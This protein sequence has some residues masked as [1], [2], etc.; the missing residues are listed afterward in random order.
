MQVFSFSIVSWALKEKITAPAPSFTPTPR[1]GQLHQSIQTDAVRHRVVDFSFIPSTP[2]WKPGCQ[3]YCIVLD[4]IV[5]PHSGIR[6]C[7]RWCCR[8]SGTT[9]GHLSS[10]PYTGIWSKSDLIFLIQ[11]LFLHFVLTKPTRGTTSR[12][13][14]RW[15]HSTNI[16]PYWANLSFTHPYRVM[17]P[18]GA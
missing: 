17:G 18:Y 8:F 11:T 7:A 14:P 4:R 2:W 6:C 15:G 9:F 1:H 13:R 5:S 16:C 3:T 10:S 12:M